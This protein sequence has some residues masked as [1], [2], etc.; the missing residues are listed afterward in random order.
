MSTEITWKNLSK[1][2]FKKTDLKGTTD[3]SR[4]WFLSRLLCTLISL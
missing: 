2:G 4:Q 3:L 1:A